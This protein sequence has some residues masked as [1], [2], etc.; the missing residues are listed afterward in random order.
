M[1][2]PRQKQYR[3]PLLTTVTTN[4]ATTTSTTNTT[5]ATTSTVSSNASCPKLK[6][7][8]PFQFPP[9]PVLIGLD[10]R[11]ILTHYIDGHVIYESDKPFPVSV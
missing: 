2:Q 1:Q 3:Q 7:T 6:S 8:T 10:D 5:T 4:T 11:R 9:P